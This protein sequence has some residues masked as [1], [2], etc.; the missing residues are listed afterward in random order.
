MTKFYQYDDSIK[1]FSSGNT[2]FPALVSK[3]SGDLVICLHG[4]P[5]NLYS[6]REQLVTLSNAGYTVVCPA[7]PG[8]AVGNRLPQG[9]DMD[10]V[11][12][13]LI[14][15]IKVIR[16]HYGQAKPVHLVG[17]DWG[18]ISGFAC[19]SKAPA[20][21]RSFTSLTI[22]YNLSLKRVLS[23]SL[24][25]LAASWYIQL[26]QL[27]G[28]S[29]AIIRSQ[30]GKFIDLLYRLWSPHWQ[31]PAAHL[32]GVKRTLFDQQTLT[33]VLGYYRAIYGLSPAA[34]K[35]RQLLNAEIHTPTM[36]IKSENDG[37]I[38]SSLWNSLDTSSFHQEVALHTL[39]CGHFPQMERPEAVSELLLAWLK[40]Y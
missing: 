20:M 38:H 8:Y 39:N 7:L 6:F 25:Y 28:I 10:A 40:R 12:D 29:E 22:P 23:H 37:C 24:S 15:M 1:T 13:A 14:G 9:Y 17:H 16:Q 2:Q 31:V 33:E 4:F 27:R 5:D 3:P 26:F 36:L 35:G 32:A 21:F 18:A 11:S 19:V 30:Q 34:I